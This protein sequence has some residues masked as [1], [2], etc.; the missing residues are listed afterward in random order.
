MIFFVRATCVLMMCGAAFGVDLFGQALSELEQARTSG[1]Q[2][3]AHEE[4]AARLFG[5]AYSEGGLTADQ[6]CTYGAFLLER[7][8]D[9]AIDVYADAIARGHAEAAGHLGRIQALLAVFP[10][11]ADELLPA[12]TQAADAVET[13]GAQGSV[14]ALRGDYYWRKGMYDLA[15]EDWKRALTLDA[16]QRQAKLGLAAVAFMDADV[17]AATQALGNLGEMTPVEQASA[18]H[19]L[20]DA[21]SVFSESGAAFADTAENHV[22]YASLL[23]ATQAPAAFGQA[24]LPL[25]RAV[26]LAPDNYV[27]WNF[28]GGLRRQAGDLQGAREAYQ[29]SLMAHPDQ[30]YT[31]S[32]LEE[33]QGE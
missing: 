8:P 27:A 22:A 28:L 10:Y 19:Y 26:Q 23:M 17:V 25:E 11:R 5:E 18:G 21:Y 13:P 9:L 32:L 20:R 6:L 30:P 16:D 7:S 15:E 33:L 29:R 1:D 24:M 3:P 31:Q 12:L 14:C 4:A 2:A